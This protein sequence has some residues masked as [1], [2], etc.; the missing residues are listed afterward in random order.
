M[1]NRG[2]ELI[3]LATDWLEDVDSGGCAKN[4]LKALKSS[5]EK[6]QHT[7]RNVQILMEFLTKNLPDH[8]GAAQDFTELAIWLVRRVKRAYWVLVSIWNFITALYKFMDLWEY[9]VALVPVLNIE[10]KSLQKKDEK[11]YLNLTTYLA[12]AYLQLHQNGYSNKV[13]LEG[14]LRNFSTLLK[15]SATPK[16]YKTFVEHLQKIF[17]KKYRYGQRLIETDK[18]LGSVFLSNILDVL[19]SLPEQ[20]MENRDSVS[21]IF[22]TYTDLLETFMAF[23]LKNNNPELSMSTRFTNI[24][25][26]SN[27]FTEIE[28]KCIE[29]LHILCVIFAKKKLKESEKLCEVF[30]KKIED[31]R[32]SLDETSVVDTFATIALI[33]DKLGLKLGEDLTMNGCLS[34]IRSISTQITVQT[35]NRKNFCRFC[36]NSDS[37]KHCIATLISVALNL[38][39]SATKKSQEVPGLTFEAILSY[40]KHNFYIMGRFK[41]SQKETLMVDFSRRIFNVFLYIKQADV[42]MYVLKTMQL[43]LENITKYN[44]DSGKRHHILKFMLRF[45]LEVQKD[46]Q[47]ALNVGVLSLLLLIE[48]DNLSTEEIA[49]EIQK[50]LH[51]ILFGF[52]DIRPTNL[53][54]VIEDESFSWY[55]TKVKYDACKLLMAQIASYETLA[56]KPLHLCAMKKLC[57][58]TQDPRILTTAFMHIPE[59]LYANFK[60]DLKNLLDLVPAQEDYADKNLHMA[61]LH[62]ANFSWKFQ[63]LQ[64]TFSEETLTEVM[65]NNQEWKI[66]EKIN[67]QDEI[68]NVLDIQKSVKYFKKFTNDSPWEHKQ[69]HHVLR[70]MKNMACDAKLYGA[71]REAVALYDL[72]YQISHKINHSE[73]ISTSLSNVLFYWK[74][75]EDIK[76]SETILCE[77]VKANAKLIAGEVRNLGGS[78]T[79]QQAL[80]ISYLLNY[81]LFCAAKGAIASSCHYLR[82]VHFSEKC[83]MSHAKFM[84]QITNYIKSGI[85]F[86][87]DIAY[88]MPLE[89]IRQL[90]E[91]SVVRFDT[92]GVNSYA[93]MILKFFL[94]TGM[95]LQVTELLL[96][97]AKIDLAQEKV[98]N[99]KSKLFYFIKILHLDELPNGS[100]I[101]SWQK[102][103]VPASNAIIPTQWQAVESAR[104]MFLKHPSKCQCLLCLQSKLTEVSQQMIL[105]FIWILFIE[106]QYERSICIS[107]HLKMDKHLQPYEVKSRGLLANALV[108]LGKEE[109]SMMECKKTLEMCDLLRNQRAACRQGVELQIV[110]LQYTMNRQENIAPIDENDDATVKQET[111]SKGFERNSAVTSAVEFQNRL[112]ICSDGSGQSEGNDRL[113]NKDVKVSGKVNGT[114]GTRIPTRKGRQT[115]K[116]NAEEE[117]VGKTKKPPAKMEK[118]STRSTKRI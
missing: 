80:V 16:N 48:K 54:D 112:E 77:M 24:W 7:D 14:L 78:E 83:R 41:C 103:D 1:P 35:N 9:M 118:K 91:Y 53:I 42:Q 47:Q 34:I 82:A 100:W 10:E 20:F 95:V 19:E 106:K 89:I 65:L 68:Q 44:I 46:M 116:I 75:Y 110:S 98:E 61:F 114:T 60:K 12:T 63:A 38:F 8:K 29:V 40:I 49:G 50:N 109:E 117:V 107:R 87:K 94:K 30:Q 57:N 56:S 79:K 113:P 69:I 36:S 18:S 71:V 66:L 11:I 21:E 74:I 25:K 31:L 85:K 58:I 15:L 39:G 37:K 2:E 62:Y 26:K 73:S 33:M 86:T 52:R 45:Y 13:Y 5:V 101:N 59:R 28:K 22:L 55:G 6:L 70:I 23:E 4:K 108:K 51:Y 17:D 81:A 84:Q 96:I 99:C 27:I 3:K 72:I 43:L 102:T 76:S 93:L 32:G 88:L 90:A 105:F 104:E 64:V 115:K 92:T 111:P 97:T 67:I